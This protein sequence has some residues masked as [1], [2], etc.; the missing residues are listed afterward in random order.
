MVEEAVSGRTFAI[1]LAGV[2]QEMSLMFWL[3]QYQP[4]SGRTYQSVWT[5]WTRQPGWNQRPDRRCADE[6][7]DAG[8]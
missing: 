7:L 1:M 3:A 6:R 2:A 8:P 4:A 5:T